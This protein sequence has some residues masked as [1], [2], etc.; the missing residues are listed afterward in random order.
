M[1]R[2]NLIKRDLEKHVFVGAKDDGRHLLRCGACG[3]PL[4]EILVTN[5]DIDVETVVAAKCDHC[6]DR[7]FNETIKGTF[8]MLTTDESILVGAEPETS[9]DGEPVVVFKTKAVVGDAKK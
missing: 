5:K 4:V 8:G 9:S 1:A 7:S 6:G 2:L 3:V